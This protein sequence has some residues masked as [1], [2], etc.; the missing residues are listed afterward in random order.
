[1]STRLV[2][3]DLR[4]LW[5]KLDNIEQLIA[6]IKQENIH[7]S[8]I[9]KSNSDNFLRLDQSLA[10]LRSVMPLKNTMEVQQCTSDPSVRQVPNKSGVLEQDIAENYQICVRIADG[11]RLRLPNQRITTRTA[12]LSSYWRRVTLEGLKEKKYH[13]L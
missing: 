13:Q 7:Y 11:G 10:S 5:N 12:R 2:E 8:K 3:G 9:M 6:E 1:P 4:I